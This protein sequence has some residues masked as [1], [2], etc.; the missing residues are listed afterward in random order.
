MDINTTGLYNKDC[1]GDT[2]FTD[3]R[4]FKDDQD[5]VCVMFR[6]A[7]IIIHIECPLL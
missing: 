2:D 5:Q 3:L 4:N 7:L 6:T 1:F